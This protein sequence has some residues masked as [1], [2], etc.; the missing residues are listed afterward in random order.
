M[1]MHTIIISIL[2]LTI[3]NCI[4][5]CRIFI[6]S[7]FESKCFILCFSYSREASYCA[8]GFQPRGQRFKSLWGLLCGKLYSSGFLI[9]KD[10]MVHTS[11]Q[12]QSQYISWS[13]KKTILHQ[14]C[15]ILISGFSMFEL[16]E[17]KELNMCFVMSASLS[18]CDFFIFHWS[19]LSCSAVTV[20]HL[21]RLTICELI[22]GTWKLAIKVL[23]LLMWSLQTWRI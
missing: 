6:L 18:L 10:C 19:P 11:P 2:F 3:G 22:F 1:L 12:F 8:L 14:H 5:L 15:W 13:Q 7:I 21:Y 9:S 4:S 20:K 23:T 16:R 17:G